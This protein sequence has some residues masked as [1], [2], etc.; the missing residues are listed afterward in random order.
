MTRAKPPA[1]TVSDWVWIHRLG[2]SHK[3]SSFWSAPWQTTAQLVPATFHLVDESRWHAN[4]LRKVAPPSDSDQA[5][6]IERRHADVDYDVPEA[7][8]ETPATYPPELDAP[9]EP[10]QLGLCPAWAHQRPSYLKDY[11]TDF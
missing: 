7:R 3:L 8:P 4:H 10:L 1:L 9:A 2:R 6:A 5:A 11:V